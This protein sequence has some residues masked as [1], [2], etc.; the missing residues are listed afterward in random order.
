MCKNLFRK[1]NKINFAKKVSNCILSGK[2][3]IYG[4]WGIICYRIS[5]FLCYDLKN[6]LEIII[7]YNTTIYVYKFYI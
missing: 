4:D 7:L 1:F 6:I 2:I 5:D 3:H